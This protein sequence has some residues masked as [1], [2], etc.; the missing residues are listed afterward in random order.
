MNIHIDL[1]Q[2][3]GSCNLFATNSANIVG[4]NII[5]STGE[6][7]HCKNRINTTPTI[8]GMYYK[9]ITPIN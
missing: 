2:S 3:L 6:R 1:H 5:D 7:K 8:L 9:R 4:S